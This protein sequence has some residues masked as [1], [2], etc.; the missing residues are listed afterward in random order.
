[1]T[2][3][4]ALVAFLILAALPAIVGACIGAAYATDQELKLGVEE[5]LEAARDR[6]TAAT[7]AGDFVNPVDQATVNRL[8]RE[9]EERLDNA[10]RDGVVGAYRWLWGLVC[11]IWDLIKGPDIDR[12]WPLAVAWGGGFYGAFGAGF[13]WAEPEPGHVLLLLTAALVFIAARPRAEVVAP[14]AEVVV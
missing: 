7:M 9:S 10:V 4:L 1:M 13:G 11:R 5:D 2:L 12:A 6:I 3:F 8:L 14:K